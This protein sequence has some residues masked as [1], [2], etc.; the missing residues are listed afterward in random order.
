MPTMNIKLTGSPLPAYAKPG[1]AAFDLCLNIEEP[2]TLQPDQTIK[3][4]TGLAVEIPEGHFGLVVPRSSLAK[5]NLMMANTL[6]IIDSGYRGE[7]LTVIRNIGTTPEVLNPQ[8]RL[9]QM[10]IIPFTQ[11]QFN[12]VESLSETER[13][14]GGFGSTDYMNQ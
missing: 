11:V 9:F 3:I 13:N 1:D 6:G 7:I 12:H 2:I 4:G 14:A 10:A 8:D 5:R